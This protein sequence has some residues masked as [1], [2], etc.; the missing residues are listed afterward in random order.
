M[1]ELAGNLQQPLTF[2][3]Y[4]SAI[5]AIIVTGF[6]IKLIVDLSGFVNS[7]ESLLTAIQQEISPTLKEIN[8]A[9]KSLNNIASGTETKFNAVS[10]SVD[11]GFDNISKSAQKALN[12]GKDI[13]LHIK[14]G[15]KAG[16]KC[17]FNSSK[18]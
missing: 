3:I 13:T 6:V 10:Q 12:K 15:I 16:L 2:L 4:S 14:N 7:A 11:K 18:S 8:S 17:Y 9:L 5:M 1:E